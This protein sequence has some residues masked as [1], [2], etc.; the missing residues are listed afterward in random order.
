MNKQKAQVTKEQH[1]HYVVR[2][3]V[4]LPYA[5]GVKVI[6]KAGK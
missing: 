6:A 4:A 3:Y 5:S 2:G 1:S